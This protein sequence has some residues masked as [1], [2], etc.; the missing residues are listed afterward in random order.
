MIKLF[1]ILFFFFSLQAHEKAD[2]DF[3]GVRQALIITIESMPLGI[4][5]KLQAL[6]NLWEGFQEANQ[7]LK[8]TKEYQDSEKALQALSK[9]WQVFQKANR[10]LKNTKEYQNFSE[11][12]AEE[13]AILTLRNTKEYQDFEKAFQALNKARLTFWKAF[14]TLKNTKES[15][16]KE[17]AQ[18]DIATKK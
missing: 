3:E 2:Q 13:K 5:R 6:S 1:S 4:N 12:Q 18:R 8:N 9:S 16:A 7:A 11:G 15:H 14:Q 17:K 10:A